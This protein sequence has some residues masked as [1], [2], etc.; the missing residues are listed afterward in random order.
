MSLPEYTG[1]WKLLYEWQTIVTGGLAIIAAIIGGVAVYCAGRV[2]AKETRNAG[3]LQ[4]AAI[5]AELNHL[6]AEKED[7]D[8]RARYDLIIALSTEVIRIEQ[9]ARLKHDTANRR[10][11]TQRPDP[12]LGTVV[13]APIVTQPNLY[14]ISTPS[15]LRE[16]R[17]VTTLLPKEVLRAV[18]SLINSVD[19]LN[20]LVEVKGNLLG[21]LQGRELLD[22]LQRVSDNA[23]ELQTA[24]EGELESR[25][26]KT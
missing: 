9:L 6:K 24:L 26:S 19:L 22:T 2:Q 1:F 12:R 15:V 20:A 14:F 11:N 5:N 25:A 18:I 3:E 16:A 10:H 21:E 13:T 8:Q 17:G 7:A 23:R 4:A